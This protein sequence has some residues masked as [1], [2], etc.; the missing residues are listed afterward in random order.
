MYFVYKYSPNNPQTIDG[1]TRKC[2]WLPYGLVLATANRSFRQV[3]RCSGEICKISLVGTFTRT[4][5]ASRRGVVH[6]LWSGSVVRVAWNVKGRVLFYLFGLRRTSS[7]LL[8]V[9]VMIGWWLEALNPIVIRYSWYG[10]SN[11]VCFVR[12]DRKYLLYYCFCPLISS[13]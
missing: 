1:W 3:T 9:I 2:L 8:G 5:C 12:L 7:N 6:I 11:N 4:T 13:G 10:K